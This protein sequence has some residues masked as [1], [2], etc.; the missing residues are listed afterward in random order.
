MAW[1]LTTQLVVRDQVVYYRSLLVAR[2]IPLANIQA[3]M[4][5]IGFDSWK[6]FQRVTFALRERQGR[7]RREIVINAGLFDGRQT[8]RWVDALNS[9]LR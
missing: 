4:F 1:C 8:K 9:E 6:P 5:Q 2:Q 3:V 7:R